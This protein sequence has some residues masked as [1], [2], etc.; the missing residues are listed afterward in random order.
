MRDWGAV[1]EWI[2]S[3]KPF[4]READHPAH[5]GHGAYPFMGGMVGMKPSG[6]SEDQMKKA[7]NWLLD[8]NFYS[9]A[10]WKYGKEFND[11]DL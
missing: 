4:M 3:E 2:R 1:Y 10:R 8:Q 7:F 11:N 6:F 5:N 9:E